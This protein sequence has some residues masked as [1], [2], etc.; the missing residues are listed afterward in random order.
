MSARPGHLRRPLSM[1][2]AGAAALLT[3]CATDDP[4]QGG[5]F[6]GLIGLGSGAYQER[7][8]TE[9]AA[10]DAE[11]ARYQGEL[12]SQAHLDLSLTERRAQA[13][14]LGDQLASLRAEV[15][16]LDAEIAVL[17]DEESVTVEQVERAEADVAT[18]LDDIDRIEQDRTAIEEAR[19]IG[20]DAGPDAD[21]SEFGEPPREQV[22]ELRAYINKLQEAVDALK[23]ARER[24]T[25]A[26]GDEPAEKTD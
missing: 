17:Q 15:D 9:E 21:P 7:V 8:V 4:N 24:R 20:A 13:A 16:V 6:G 18:L 1:L 2:M 14:E 23:S 25:Q 26:A 3:G 19:A 11:E 10:L 12:D 22:S 5:L